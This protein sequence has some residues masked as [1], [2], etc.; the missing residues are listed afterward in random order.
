MDFQ[1][2]VEFISKV[3]KCYKGPK[4]FGITALVDHFN[5]IMKTTN[6]SLTHRLMNKTILSLLRLS[7]GY[8]KC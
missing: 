8:Q 7:K 1:L 4:A 6:I 3:I 5:V 2:D